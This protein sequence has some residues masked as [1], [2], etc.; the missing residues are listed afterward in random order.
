M[1]TKFSLFS[2]SF[3]IFLFSLTFSTLVFAKPLSP[4][5]R[6]ILTADLGPSR[7]K[8]FVGNIPDVQDVGIFRPI[9]IPTKFSQFDVNPK[10][11][12]ISLIELTAASE[13]EEGARSVFKST[14]KNFDGRISILEFMR[15][16][17][18]LRP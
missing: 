17:W 18:I 13:A 10:D 15:A 9:R 16:P 12:F 1:E 14:D 3:L 5:E 4:L 7:L 8:M 6:E 2:S 11:G